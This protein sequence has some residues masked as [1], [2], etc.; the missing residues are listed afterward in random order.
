MEFELAIQLGVPGDRILFNGP[1]KSSDDLEFAARRGA[2]IHLDNLEEL[3]AL[4]SVSESL[5]EKIRLAIRCNFPLRPEHV[6]RF[7][8]DVSSGKLQEV[9]RRIR[10]NDCFRLEGLHCH[11]SHHRDA[12]SYR[13]RVEQ[14]VRLA[15]E[16]FL[17]APPKYLDIGGGF[18]G[19]MP[20]SLRMQF[21][22]PPPH[23]SDYAEAVAQVVFD[24]FG[25]QGPALIL[26]PGMGVV[27]DCVKFM[28]VVT[29]TREIRGKRF[30]TTPG[31]VYNVKPT[32]TTMNLPLEVLRAMPDVPTN[33]A[34][35][36]TDVVGSTC[37]EIDVLH[38]NLQQ[39]LS[40]GDIL[41]FSNV[42]A[43]TNVLLPPFIRPAPAMLALEQG[44][45]SLIR[46]EQ[47]T[48]DVFSTY[49]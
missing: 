16:V 49:L 17:D 20:E 44:Q 42:G 39:P 1:W 27:A 32:L 18:C 48:N 3:A 13:T 46:R 29:S 41:I 43:Y 21:P 22:T 14:M 30:A 2:F 7:G 11:F 9:A 33:D 40:T 10:R 15:K 4:E 12:A 47:T 19:N 34:T 23:Y 37:M 38:R 25:A 31:S 35:I 5:D 36:P 28:T 26:E 8:F 6:S 45:V 24:E